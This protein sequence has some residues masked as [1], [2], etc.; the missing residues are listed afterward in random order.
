MGWDIGSVGCVLDRTQDGTLGDA[1]THG[2]ERGH[3]VGL[4]YLTVTV[5]QIGLQDE[6]IRGRK[7]AHE[8]REQALIHI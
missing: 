6:E 5:G 7:D 1:C 4:G 2:M 8:N 3:G